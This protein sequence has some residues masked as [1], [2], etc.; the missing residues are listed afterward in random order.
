MAGPCTGARRRGRR[1]RRS[2]LDAPARP[3]SA[4]VLAIG[5][6]NL[7]LHSSLTPVPISIRKDVSE[8]YLIIFTTKLRNRESSSFTFG[9]YLAIPTEAVTYSGA[10]YLL[11]V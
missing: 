2:A 6:L 11:V 7:N 1:R 3:A 8:R 5:M 10:I 4:S 9:E